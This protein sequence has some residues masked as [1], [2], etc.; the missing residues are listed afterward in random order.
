MSTTVRD[1]ATLARRRAATNA[2]AAYAQ[3]A[4]SRRENFAQLRE[5]G[6]TIAEGAQRMGV[7]YEQ[8][9]RWDAKLRADNPGYQP[10]RRRYSTPH[11][12]R[13]MRVAEGR[14]QAYLEL[15]AQ[16]L[17]PERIAQRLGVKL[18]TVQRY[19]RRHR[20]ESGIRSWWGHQ[21]AELRPRVLA[22][23]QQWPGVVFSAYDLERKVGL[24][25]GGNRN[26]NTYTVRAIMRD[27]VAE[28]IAELLP[29]VCDRAVAPSNVPVR[30]YRFRADM[31]RA[32]ITVGG[33][34]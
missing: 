25:E 17:K 18:G 11:V 31:S 12:T 19:Q 4:A 9:R 23:L 20:R 27:L 15:L 34:A 3:Q 33:G 7:S 24:H 29:G 22:H 2:R 26:A 6:A 10:S 14:Y 1:T 32:D 21:Y 8:A 5:R 28:G 13:Q 16:G 30:R